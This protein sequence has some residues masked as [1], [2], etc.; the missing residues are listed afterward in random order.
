MFGRASKLAPAPCEAPPNGVPCRISTRGARE[1]A[2]YGVQRR[3]QSHEN[4]CDSSGSSM[5]SRSMDFHELYGVVRPVW[6]GFQTGSG[7]M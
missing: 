6:Q 2:L 3:R 7:S 4:V 5:K 1:I